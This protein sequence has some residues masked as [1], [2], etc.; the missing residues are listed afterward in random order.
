[1]SKG[2]VDEAGTARVN[3]KFF[4]IEP[5]TS[6]MH[7]RH[8]MIDLVHAFKERAAFTSR[9][10]L[11][12]IP[13]GPYAHQYVYFDLATGNGRLLMA[14]PGP[15]LEEGRRLWDA[16]EAHYP[17]ELMPATRLT[18]ADWQRNADEWNQ[19]LVVRDA[20]AAAAKANATK[21]ASPAVSAAPGG[22]N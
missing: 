17:G 21:Q 5:S 19:Y 18:L 7:I 15:E 16:M 6:R 13:A 20:K 9:H 14:R 3:S 10:L 12:A 8:R 2:E 1:M 4:G 22:S 11:A